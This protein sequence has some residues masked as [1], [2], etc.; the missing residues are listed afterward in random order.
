MSVVNSPWSDDVNT[1]PHRQD[2][3]GLKHF[4]GVELFTLDNCNNVDVLLGNDNAHLMWAKE[5]RLGKNITDLHAI[6]TPLGWL[7]CGGQSSQEG[8]TAK[9]VEQI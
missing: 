3:S 4:D 7:A 8:S 6:L 5:E 9:V 1:L 2:L